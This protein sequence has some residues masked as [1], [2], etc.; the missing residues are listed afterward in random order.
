L[1]AQ[2]VP[3]RTVLHYL[4]FSMLELQLCIGLL[5]SNDIKRNV[6]G[7]E[8]LVALTTVGDQRDAA[9]PEASLAILYRRESMSIEGCLRNSFLPHLCKI[10][11]I[12]T[13]DDHTVWDEDDEAARGKGSWD[14]L[15]TLALRVLANALEQI[16]LL[17]KPSPFDF[18]DTA[19]GCIVSTLIHNIELSRSSE[20]AECSLKCL[21]LLHTLEPY[22]ITPLLGQTLL[23]YLVNL[24]EYGKLKRFPIIESEASRLL[25]GTELGIC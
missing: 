12:R 20:I 23:P 7:M 19:W 14:D 13:E 4:K 17:P 3:K 2:I 15:N 5:S 16:S 22:D 21:R 18:S 6:A 10:Q 8:L 1:R 24:Q 9:E 25:K 11:E